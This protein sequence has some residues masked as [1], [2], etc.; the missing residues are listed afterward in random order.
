MIKMHNFF[1]WFVTFKYFMTTLKIFSIIIPSAVILY[2]AA[3]LC[4]GTYP[5]FHTKAQHKRSRHT[6]E[7]WPSKVRASF[8]VKK[9]KGWSQKCNKTDETGLQSSLHICRNCMQFE[10]AS[11]KCPKRYLLT[12]WPEE[13]QLS[14][15]KVQ[16][17]VVLETWTFLWPLHQQWAVKLL[18]KVS[19]LNTWVTLALCNGNHSFFNI[20]EVKIQSQEA[21]LAKLSNH[22]NS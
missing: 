14:K 12:G 2:L 1:L 9:H 8:V 6:L 19:L 3:W 7:Q 11:I 18:P 21:N 10:A 22:I 4:S 16:F 5:S 17:L 15:H 20:Q 13:N